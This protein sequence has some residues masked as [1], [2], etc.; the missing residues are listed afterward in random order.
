MNAYR[1]AFWVIT[2]RYMDDFQFNEDR[3]KTKMV[4]KLRRKTIPKSWWISTTTTHR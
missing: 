2:R 1:N 4:P 3:S